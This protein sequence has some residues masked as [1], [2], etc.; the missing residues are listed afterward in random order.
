MKT[1]I[2]FLMFVTLLT[3]TTSC[4][5]DYFETDKISTHIQWEPNFAIAAVNTSLTIRDVLR[6]YDTTH[7]FVEDQTGFL[8]LMYNKRIFSLPAKDIVTIPDINLSSQF[9]SSEYA[10]LGFPVPNATVPVTHNM[11]AVLALV[12]SEIFDSL[13]VK[14]CELGVHFNT[15]FQHNGVLTITLPNAK[16]NGQAYSHNIPVA[17]G[18]NVNE[19]LFNLA[20]Y[21]IDM[22]QTGTNQFPV[23][24]TY[25]LTSSGN[26]VVPADV[27]DLSL[28][29]TNIQ[30]DYIFGDMGNYIINLNPD[31]VHIDIFDKAFDG[32]VYFMD[33]KFRLIMTNSFGVPM[34]IGLSDFL[35]YSTATNAYSPYS[36]PAQ[37]NPFLISASQYPSPYAV[38][39][40][41]LDTTNFPLIR[42]IVQNSPKYVFFSAVGATV[43][44]LP[45]QKQFISDSSRFS[46]DLEVELPMWGRASLFA[47]QDTVDFDFMETIK[48]SGDFTLDNIEYIIFKLNVTNGLP[49]DAAVQ[50]YFTDTLTDVFGH[51]IVY[52]SLFYSPTA[53]QIV[54][55]GVLGS[56]GRVISPTLHA[57]EIKFDN[58]RLQKLRPSK[59][60]LIKGTLKTTGNGNQNVRFYSDYDLKVKMG[61]RVQASV[62]SQQFD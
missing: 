9:T 29:F 18:Q 44:P 4:F 40:L 59:K 17:A 16:A 7:L 35:I 52:D 38:S 14:H 45:G 39:T 58:P 19:V 5:K 6:D 54:H 22:T 47:M 50:V 37:Y 30:Y 51:Y 13:R 27:A 62:N 28:S 53:A 60:I 46:V 23:L 20:G 32:Y 15:S 3:I 2:R 10:A 34:A 36:F 41:Q 42:D 48:D 57:T 12:H 1:G 55:S 25:T 33:P 26:P 24:V 21:T 56:N 61:L 8:Y 11:T 31:T 43:P 49:T